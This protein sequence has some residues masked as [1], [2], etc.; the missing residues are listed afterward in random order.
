VGR[1]KNHPVSNRVMMMMMMFLPILQYYCTLEL[2]YKEECSSNV[3][4]KSN[5]ISLVLCMSR[6]ANELIESS[7]RRT[8]DF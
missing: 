3:G 2:S 8:E 1:E 7:L 5:D 6:P 4:L